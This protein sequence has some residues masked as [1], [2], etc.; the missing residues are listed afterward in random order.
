M[1]VSV[2]SLCSGR[3]SRLHQ[4]SEK[5]LGGAQDDPGA[6]GDPRIPWE[7]ADLLEATWN[8]PETDTHTSTPRGRRPRIDRNGSPRRNM[9]NVKEEEEEE[10]EYKLESQT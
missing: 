7:A 6:T 1:F 8:W 5:L 3:I 4:A 9:A 10:E 2:C